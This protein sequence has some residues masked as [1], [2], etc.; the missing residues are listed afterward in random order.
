MKLVHTQEMERPFEVL[1]NTPRGQAALMVLEPGRST[2]GPDNRHPDSD[3]WMLV[4]AGRGTAL[5]E[6]HELPLGPGVLLVIEQGEA[7]EIRSTGT[8][9]LRSVNFY[10]PPAY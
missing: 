4:L 3:Q 8:E 2:G 9:P 7:H 5:V 6:G 1:A 10:T